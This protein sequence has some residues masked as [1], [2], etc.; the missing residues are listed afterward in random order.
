M[1]DKMIDKKALALLKKSKRNLLSDDERKYC[2]KNGVLWEHEPVLHNELICQIKKLAEKISLD[3]AVKA[4]LYS[5]SSG[6][7]RYRTVLS[8]LIWARALP[9]HE[10]IASSNYIGRIS[11]SI[12]GATISKETEK[13]CFDML[14]YNAMRIIPEKIVMDTCC[15]GYVLNDLNEFVKLPEVMYCDEDFRIINRIFGLV[16][17]ISPTNKVNALLKLISIEKSLNLTSANAYSILGVL[18]SCGIFDTPQYKSYA[19]GFVNYDN[20]KFSYETDIYYPLNL[21]RGKHGVNYSAI[22]EIFGKDISTQI[23]AETAI[24]GMA[25]YEESKK[26]ISRSKAEQYFIDGE[27]IIDLDDRQRYYYGLAPMN[28]G[29]DR[30]VVFSVTYNCNKR[31]EIF[32]EGN[33][34]KKIIYEEYNSNSEYRTYM[35]ADMDTLTNNRRFILPKTSRGREQP[36][37][38]SLL[39]TPTYMLGQFYVA[40]GG[41]AVRRFSGVSS[42]NSSNDQELPLPDRI[43]DTKEDFIKYT[44]EYIASCPENYSKQIDNFRN[45]KRVTV[46]FSAG[47]IFKVQLTPTLCTY[48]IILGK[49][50]QIEKWPEISDKHPI[51]NLM[52]QPIIYR[53]YAIVTDKAD[54]TVE[55]LKDIPLLDAKISQD[56][57]I[58]W[59]KY[60]IVCSKKLE[61]SDIDIGFGI[62][63]KTKIVTWGLSIHTFKEGEL[64]IFNDEEN[65]S[66]GEVS[67][68]THTG[69]VTYNGVSVRINVHNNEFKAGVIPYE[70]NQKSRLKKRIARQL[71]FNEETACDEF[72]EMFGGITRKQFIELAEERFKW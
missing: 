26:K 49:V 59:E 4:F 12:C 37:T 1:G 40:L 53:Q 63:N 19:S 56:N 36:L 33:T 7:F 8:S 17:E 30:E 25:E 21:W 16:K 3:N 61:E 50:R 52:T 14:Y 22:S 39:Q 45:K 72:A 67:A 60:P 15:A 51:R 48:G 69:R 65:I 57:E 27:H 18:S 71:G 62:N 68:I 35:E 32:Y 9:E 38:P 58:I 55:E 41:E 64:D 28:L 10:C 66:I 70:E 31:T 43:L 5:V 54:M 11:C 2:I 20:S 47:D 44:E 46:Q 6:D 34:V 24:C 42:F 13:T 23:S 29:W